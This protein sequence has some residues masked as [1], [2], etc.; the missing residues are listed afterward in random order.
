[1][2]RFEGLEY[3]VSGLGVSRFWVS[4]FGVSGGSWFWRFGFSMYGVSQVR[5]YR[6]RFSRFGLSGWGFLRFGVSGSGFWFSVQDFRGCA[7]VC[8]AVRG[9]GYGVTWFGVSV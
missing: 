4:V 2:S 6:L 8:L 3:A 7:V 5:G 1:M 9:F